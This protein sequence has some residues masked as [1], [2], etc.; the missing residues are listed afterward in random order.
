MMQKVGPAALKQHFMI[1]DTICDATQ[2]RQDAVYDM[3]G[4]QDQVPA[5]TALHRH[6]PPAAIWPACSVL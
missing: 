4:K 5:D 2:E 1:M 3:V 6:T